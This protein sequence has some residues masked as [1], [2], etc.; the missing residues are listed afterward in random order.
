MNEPSPEVAQA[1]HP[2]GLVV[3]FLAEMWER[4]CYYGMRTLLTLYLTESLLM[5]DEDAFT[6][7]GAYTALVY[8]APVLGGRLA[9][10]LLGYQRAV[11][12]GGIL[13]AVGEFTLIGHRFVGGGPELATTLLYLGMGIII[14]GNGYFKANISSIVGK[15]YDDKPHLKDSG[16]TIFYIGINIGALLAT[17]VCAWVGATYGREMGFGLAGVGMLFGLVQFVF[18]RAKLEGKGL[19]PD[20]ERLNKPVFGPL[21]RWHITVLASVAAGPALYFLLTND[22]IVGYLLL[23]VAIYVAV[24]LLLAASKEGKVQVHRTIALFIFMILNVMWWALFEQ[25]GTS[26]T[27]FADRAVDRMVF[28]WEMP[29]ENT[30]FFNPFF[31]VV[32]GSI[33]STMWV[34][35]DEANKNP[36]IPIKFGLAFLQ[37]ALG[38]YMLVIGSQFVGETF[39]VPLTFLALLY[40]LHTTGELFLSPIG[41]SLATKLAPKGMAGSVMGAWFLSFAGANFVGGQIA[42]LTGGEGEAEAETEAAGEA[43]GEVAQGVAQTAQEAAAAAQQVLETYVDA[44]ASFAYAIAAV[45]ILVLVLNKPFN[46]LMH[47]VK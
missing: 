13:M 14:I 4:F 47:G 34:K 38:Y 32:F 28:G 23:G 20:E 7:Y 44:Y 39:K 17:T 1:R 10:K 21:S 24:S 22:S 29:A 36:N 11:I 19:P 33:F 6:T 2:R 5:G 9:D 40:L 35:L 30:Q 41:L 31:I 46:K 12:L 25:A 26:L 3:L 18:G 15:L 27:L 43:A 8:A 45:G 16:F 42:K 37:L